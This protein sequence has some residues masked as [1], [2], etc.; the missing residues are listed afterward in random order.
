MSILGT[1]Q[2]NGDGSYIIDPDGY[3]VGAAPFEV[4][5]DMSTDGGGWTQFFYNQ[6]GDAGGYSAL[7]ASVFSDVSA[8]ALGSGSY[9]HSAVE[10]LTTASELR[11]SE[12]LNTISDSRTPFWTYDYSCQITADVLDKIATPGYMNQVPAAVSCTDLGTGNVATNAV[13]FNYQGWS[14][15]WTGPRL[16]IG[17]TAGSNYH[18]DYCV[19]CIST[20]KC[21]DTINGVYSGPSAGYYTSVAIWLR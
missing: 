1:P 17:S 5:C 8:G 19:G 18:G 9:K 21:G 3:A 6:A 14:G 20:W 15:C 7:Y 12:P 16:W 10:L 11:Y 2:D 13:Y 4:Y